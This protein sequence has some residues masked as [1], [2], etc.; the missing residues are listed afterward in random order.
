MNGRLAIGM[1]IGHTNHVI[2]VID[3]A[4]GCDSRVPDILRA[5]SVLEQIVSQ[6]N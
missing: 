6:R 2:L 4:V 1:D 5:E 3:G